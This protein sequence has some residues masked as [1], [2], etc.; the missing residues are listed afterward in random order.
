[1]I[2]GFYSVASALTAAEMN[3]EVVAENLANAT[4]GGYRRS[5]VVF[6]TADDDDSQEAGNAN[7]RGRSVRATGQYTSFEPGPMQQ[8]GNALD[9]ALS[10]N[11]YFVVDGPNGPLYT[12]NGA[13]TRTA[14]G[15]LQ[16]ATGLAVRGAGGPITLPANA[17]KIT[18]SQEGAI[19]ADNVEV[20][21]LQLAEFRDGAGL[22][23]AGTTLFDG[24]PAQAPRPGSFKVEQGY[25]EGSNVQ[26]VNEMVSMITGM[27]YYEAAE[28]ALKALEDAVSQNTKPQ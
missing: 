4:V 24:P 15:S 19:R 28:K 23:R 17:A 27:R 9:I 2:R 10:P 8:T 22:R 12:R 5:G 14:D 16:N 18:V 25:R 3:H 1:M 13:F 26:V 20:G 6:Q 11:V 21:R 7:H